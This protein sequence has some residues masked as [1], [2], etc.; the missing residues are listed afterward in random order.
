[1]SDSINPSGPPPASKGG[2]VKSVAPGSV[3]AAAGLQPHDLV[4]AING[5][6]LRDVMR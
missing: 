3:G 4:R 6:T 1:M 2:L 5:R